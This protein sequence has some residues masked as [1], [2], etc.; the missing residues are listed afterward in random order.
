MCGIAGIVALEG[1][2]PATLMKMTNLVSYRGPDGRGFVF[3]DVH[4]ASTG[5]AVHNQEILPALERPSLGF[6]ARRLA[7]LDLSELGLQ[8]MQI[9]NGDYWITYNGEIYN[10]LEIRRELEGTGDLF[11]TH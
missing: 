8:P 7:I 4:S 5:E 2:D 1:F 11:R 9:D 6:G 3:I 10:Y